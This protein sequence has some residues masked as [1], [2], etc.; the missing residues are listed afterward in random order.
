MLGI[1]GILNAQNSLALARQN[2]HAA[3]QMYLA[4][5]TRINQGLT[6]GEQCIIDEGIA[7]QARGREMKA[8]TFEYLGNA[9]NGIN[10][11]PCDQTESYE[12]DDS[13]DEN[14]SYGDESVINGDSTSINRTVSPLRQSRI[15]ISV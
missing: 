3:N 6:D 13:Y 11:A 9:M 5:N 1:G 14:S 10:N 8:G 2:R 12:Y 7:I 15:D 4:G